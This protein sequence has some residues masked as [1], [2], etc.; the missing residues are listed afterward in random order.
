MKNTVF[1]QFGVFIK[2]LEQN[3]SE[4]DD[5][6]MVLEESLPTLI[7]HFDDMKYQIQSDF[8]SIQL[9]S[10]T[11]LADFNS[12]KN[13]IEFVLINTRIDSL[14]VEAFFPIFIDEKGMIR[15]KLLT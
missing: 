1:V 13:I 15:I 5:K 12:C 9:I 14:L 7:K 3:L 8:Q 11:N 10:D 6:G 2:K 4:A